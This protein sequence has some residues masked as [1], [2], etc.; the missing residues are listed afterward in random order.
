MNRSGMGGVFTCGI[1]RRKSL[2]NRALISTIW[3]VE[4]FD[5]RG[6]LKDHSITRNRVV[7]QGLNHILDV[8]FG[9]AAQ[10]DPWYI[11]IFEDDYTP[12]AADTYQ[13]PGFTE[14]I[15]YTEAARQIFVETVASGK[16]INNTSNKAVFTINATKTI[17]G[18]ALV[19]LVTINDQTAGNFMY[20]ASNFGA[21]AVEATDTFKVSLTISAT[22]M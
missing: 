12:L 14:S 19:S 16:S 21:K 8:H 15:A 17:Y 10:I 3:E 1:E 9:G 2:R 13:V 22:D 6:N 7:D 20:C 11:L 4:V 18:G 5:G